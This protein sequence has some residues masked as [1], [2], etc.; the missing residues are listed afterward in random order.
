MFPAVLAAS[1]K[2]RFFWAA[3]VA[4]VAATLAFTW[5]WAVNARGSDVVGTDLIRIPPLH[6]ASFATGIVL[7]RARP[8]TTELLTGQR[9]T[10]LLCGAAIS[11]M[12]VALMRYSFN[13]EAWWTPLEVAVLLPLLAVVVVAAAHLGKT[14]LDRRFFI[15]LGEASYAVYILQMPILTFVTTA[16]ELSPLHPLMRA[17]IAIA[18][19]VGV[20]LAVHRLFEVPARRWIRQTLMSRA[21][22]PARAE[23]GIAPSPSSAPASDWPREAPPL[24]RHRSGP[25][26]VM[27]R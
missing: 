10:L 18:I 21:A 3:Y 27:A 22:P 13:V 2:P 9:A 11:L 20:S 25:T 15:E 12:I 4:T 6:L 24:R 5:W 16:L 17:S 19:L 8:W 7:A 1:Q 26:P 23:R 14:W